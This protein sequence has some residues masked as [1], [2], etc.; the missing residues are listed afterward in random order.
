MP[1]SYVIVMLKAYK[2]FQMVN[3]FFWNILRQLFDI[4]RIISATVNL[5]AVLQYTKKNGQCMSLLHA[6][7]FQGDLI[8]IIYCNCPHVSYKYYLY[9]EY[10]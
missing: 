1:L 4:T 8:F 6:G 5:K 2:A 10:T 7:Q 3:D 9:K